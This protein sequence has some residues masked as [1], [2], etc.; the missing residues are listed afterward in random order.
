MSIRC[1]VP[2][3]GGEVTAES[4]TQREGLSCTA[5]PTAVPPL[6]VRPASAAVPSTTSSPVLPAAPGVAPVAVAG[7]VAV[8]VEAADED[9]GGAELESVMEMDLPHPVR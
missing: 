4:W 8:G 3:I 7:V 5:G 9:A 2:R 1:G 6:P